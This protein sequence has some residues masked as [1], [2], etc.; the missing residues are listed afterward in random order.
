MEA[1]MKKEMGRSEI[2][3]SLDNNLDPLVQKIRFYPSTVNGWSR[4]SI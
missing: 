3:L 4:R 2:L 1:K